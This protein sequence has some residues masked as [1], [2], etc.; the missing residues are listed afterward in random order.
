MSYRVEIAERAQRDF[1]NLYEAID[2][3]RSDAA[4]RWYGGLKEAILSLEKLPHRCAVI[5]RKGQTKQLLYGAKPHAYPALYRIMARRKLVQVLH[6]RH[7]ARQL[8]SPSDLGLR[9]P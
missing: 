9:R 7:G 4:R 1:F 5:R 2:A 8:F 6:I 3:E